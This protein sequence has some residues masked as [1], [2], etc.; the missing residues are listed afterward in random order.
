MSDLLQ[1]ALFPVNLP[2]TILLAALAGYWL[3]VALGVFDPEGG[4]DLDAAEGDVG[5][6]GGAWSAFLHFLNIGE[7]P[8]MIV[9]SVL[10]LCMWALSMM[11]NFFLNDGSILL[12][13]AYLIPVFLVSAVVA[14]YATMPFRKVLK[15]LNQ[16]GPEHLPI[17][18]R[19]CTVS[20]SAVT[21]KFGQAEVL[22][23]GAPLLLQV[24]TQEGQKLARGESALI[25]G[26][27][28]AGG[29]FTVVKITNDT[30]EA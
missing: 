19:T 14:R 22:T 3:F 11:A 21:E 12:G 5:A 16:E 8:L 30:L 2:L 9:L 6:D 4:G 17:I 24:R 28:P 18:G 20:T 27:D 26:S 23:D 10:V 1:Q 29:F 7:V 25:I 13:L 15:L